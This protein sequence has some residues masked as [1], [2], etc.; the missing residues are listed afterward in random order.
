[1]LRDCS[2][3]ANDINNAKLLFGPNFHAIRGK[4]ARQS[5]QPATT[6]YIEIPKV[7]R[8]RNRNVDI[9]ADVFFINGLPFIVTRSRQLKFITAEAINT[10]GKKCSLM[11]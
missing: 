9:S 8:E 5:P 1:M 4:A 10:R 2:I 3:A 6:R 7:I 11:H